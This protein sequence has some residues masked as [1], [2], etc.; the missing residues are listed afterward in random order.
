MRACSFDDV[1]VFSDEPYHYRNRMDFVFHAKGI[2]LRADG[3]SSEIVD[4]KECVIADLAVNK[5]LLEVRDYFKGVD[6][7]DAHKRKGTFRSVIIRTSLLGDSAICFVLNDDSSLLTLAFEK[8]RS[9]ALGSCAQHILV[10]VAS[11]DSEVNFSDDFEVI[12]GEEY[13]LEEFC[14]KRFCYP[15]QG[16]FQNNPVMAGK[17]Q[18]YVHGLLAEYE[19]LSASLLDLYGGVGTFGIVN[20]AL[21]QSVMVVESA[22]ASIAMAERNALLNGVS[23]V[24]GVVLDAQHIGRLSFFGKLFVITDPPR[25]GMHPKTIRYLNE[26]KPSVII[27]ISC[28]V[29]QLAKDLMKFSDYSIKSAALFDLFPQTVHSEAVV[30]LVRKS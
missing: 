13:L 17:M 30:E 7:F 11:C 16:F 10:A 2:G 6:Y 23:N 1:K 26:I 5:L 21:F 27:Y 19:T 18:V 29:E 3:R 20:A 22:P 28:N 14:G 12:K 9:F 24:K 4:I 25:C 8:I 15:I